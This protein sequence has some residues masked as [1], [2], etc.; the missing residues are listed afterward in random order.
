MFQLVTDPDRPVIFYEWTKFF[1]SL[2]RRLPGLLSYHHFRC[3]VEHPGSILV[4]SYAD[5][6]DKE[7]K[8]LKSGVTVQLTVLPDITVNSGLD[9]ARQWYLY[10]VVRPCCPSKIMDNVCPKPTVP[11]PV[12]VVKE[13]EKE[14]RKKQT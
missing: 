4:R 7:I 6:V 5:D 13:E 1:S 8:L 14:K 10:D 11:R 9:A 3:D 12:H 2:F